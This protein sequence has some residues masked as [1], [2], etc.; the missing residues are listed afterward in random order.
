MN[1]LHLPSWYPDLRDTRLDG[2]F[3]REFAVGLAAHHPDCTVHVASWGHG[4]RELSS[5]TLRTW[6][7]RPVL[8]PLALPARRVLAPNL[9]EHR[10]PAWTW[11]Y[12]VA[13][14]NVEGVTAAMR[15]L[16]AR[17]RG[18]GVRVDLMHAQVAFPAGRVAMT[19]SAETG[20]PFVLTEHMGPFPFVAFRRGE[21]VSDDILAPIR[22]ARRVWAVSRALADDVQ[23][24]TGVRPDVVPNAVDGDFFVPGPVRPGR[25]SRFVCIGALVPAKGQEDLLHAFAQAGLGPEARLCLMGSGPSEAALRALAE[26]L[27]I[28]ARVEWRAARGREAVREVLQ[29]NDV[30]VSASRHESFGLTLVEAL[31]CARP[32]I[33]TRCGGPEDI[34]RPEDGMLVPVGDVAALAAAIGAVAR[35]ERGFD[36]GALRRGFE[37]RFS[38]PVVTGRIVREYRAVIGGA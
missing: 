36:P 29:A 11:R 21:R 24:L 33:A 15:R 20:I 8:A 37:E 5:A 28:A 17:L 27:G 31:A 6:L 30:L 12:D 7:R 14:G 38:M 3:F 16:L 34:V 1:V 22:A 25:P 9:I 13:R 32:V 23:R 10:E 18:E 4:D 35:G 26:R 2:V 19:L